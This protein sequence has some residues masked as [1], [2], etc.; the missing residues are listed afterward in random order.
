[1]NQSTSAY[2]P[3]APLGVVAEEATNTLS[4]EWSNGRTTRYPIEWLRWQCPCALCRG[5]MGIPGRLTQIDSLS[6]EE[7]RLE[8]VQPVGRYG[9]MLFW[10]DGHHD[11]IYT[12]DWLLNN[13]QDQE[14]QALTD[15]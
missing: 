5:E 8:D 2:E 11:G 15:V 13:S 12:Y 6:P 7:T 4:I 10:G 3:V 1:M 9:V 14:P